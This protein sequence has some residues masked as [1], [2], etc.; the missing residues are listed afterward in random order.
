MYQKIKHTLSAFAIAATLLAGSAL[1]GQPA[2]QRDLAA[3]ARST[4]D[5][6]PT[7]SAAQAESPRAR[8]SGLS[9]PYYAFGSLLPRAR[10]S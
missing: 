10:S 9:M 3:D 1:V 8:T 6:S 2:P 4:T 5:Q 7:A